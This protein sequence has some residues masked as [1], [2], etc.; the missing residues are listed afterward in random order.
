M[1]MDNVVGLV[2]SALLVGYLLTALILPER[3]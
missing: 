3:F 2:L 1:S